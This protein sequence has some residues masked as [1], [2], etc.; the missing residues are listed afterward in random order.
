MVMTALFSNEI[1]T[2]TMEKGGFFCLSRLLDLD[3][4]EQ[5]M[6]CV[7]EEKNAKGEIDR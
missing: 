6:A 2:Q 1:A 3:K 7:T 5:D 4:L